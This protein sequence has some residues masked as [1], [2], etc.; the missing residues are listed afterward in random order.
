[1]RCV[2]I[3]WLEVCALEPGDY[4]R[5]MQYYTSKG[6]YCEMRGYGT[7]IYNEMFTVFNNDGKY[8][9]VRRNPVKGETGGIFDKN[10]CHLRLVNRACYADRCAVDFERFLS[11]NGY[12]NVRISR[13]DICLDFTAFD[14]GDM[15]AK[16][17][18]RYMRH[19]YAK[20][21]QANITAHG[22]DEW[23][24]QTFNS[25]SWG[26]KNSPIYTKMYNK[27]M[28]L[29]NEK[30]GT[31]KKAYIMQAWFNAGLIDN[32]LACSKDGQQVDVWRVEFTIKSP[33]A[34]WVKIEKDGKKNKPQSLPNRLATYGERANLLVMFASLCQHYFR[35]KI[36]EDGQRKDRCKDKKLFLFQDIETFYQFDA[37]GGIVNDE[38]IQQKKWSR[39]RQMLCEYKEQARDPT[40]IEDCES[41]IDTIDESSLN[42]LIPMIW[43]AEERM[44][45]FDYIASYR[46]GERA[47]KQVLMDKIRQQ[48]K[49]N[50]QFIKFGQQEDE[51]VQ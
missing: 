41:L 38:S 17:V 30:T 26:S 47:K 45:F 36:Y 24:G 25:L 21:N 19:V 16:F 23:T 49:I 37:K 7:R 14:T 6:Y 33:K 44:S 28:E 46:Q 2:N 13:I 11:E 1:M 34:N 42:G 48:M 22:R 10:M 15:P 51:A 31:Y 40:V 35:F 12:E 18:A 32:L 3:D 50:K 9:E 39:L 5:D 29:Y 20:I 43:T 4:P 27:T 8:I